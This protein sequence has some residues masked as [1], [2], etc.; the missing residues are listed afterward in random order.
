[1]LGFFLYNNEPEICTIYKYKFGLAL[2]KKIYTAY[3]L[4]ANN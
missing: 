4:L 3:F 1:M 2:D